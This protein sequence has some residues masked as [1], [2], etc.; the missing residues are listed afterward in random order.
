LIVPAASVA[1]FIVRIA[2]DEVGGE[3]GGHAPN[4]AKPQTASSMHN[5]PFRLTMSN[6]P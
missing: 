3:R 1:V 2:C 4:I 6:A 5:A